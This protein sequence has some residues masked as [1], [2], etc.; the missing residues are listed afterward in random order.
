MNER[1]LIVEDDREIVDIVEMYLT[2]HGFEVVSTDAWEAVDIVQNSPVNLVVL[3][4]VLPGPNG[5]ELCQELR[6]HTDVPIVFM[7]AKADDS[8][9][10][11]GLGVGA[12]DFVPK[13]FSPSELVA[14]VKAHLRRYNGFALKQLAHRPF[15]R[16]ANMEIDEDSYT[17]MMPHATTTLSTKEF[18]IL[19]LMAQ[20]PDRV[21]KPEELFQQVWHSPSLGD[22]RTVRVHIS[23]LRKKIEQDPARPK[24][25]VTIRGVG[26]KFMAE[27]AV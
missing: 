24:Y 2:R 25:I 1:V 27:S 10:I 21:Y 17:V 13:P 6:K 19:M 12:D 23:N 20:N 8:D 5:F 3:D 26:Y 22:A 7:S 4:I 15:L 18:Q 14:R 16:L 11:L 9:R